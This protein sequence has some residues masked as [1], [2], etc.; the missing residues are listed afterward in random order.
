MA[1]E[2]EAKRGPSYTSDFPV[3]SG[4]PGSP[5][6]NEH[7]CDIAYPRSPAVSRAWA[8]FAKPLVAHD[9]SARNVTR[10][11]KSS[12]R[13]ACPSAYLMSLMD[14]DLVGAGIDQLG[15]LGVGARLE[16]VDD[17]GV[18]VPRS[19]AP[20]DHIGLRPHAGGDDL[21]VG[22][23]SASQATRSRRSNASNDWRIFS[24]FPRDGASFSSPTASR[25]YRRD[26]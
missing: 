23:R 2:A 12:G 7:V 3:Q 19:L 11:E 5:E 21:Y 13:A 20:D 24:T 17:R 1:S 14:Q 26:P 18:E 22:S 4:V 10:T 6:A 25:G 8:W 15:L 16:C 9:P